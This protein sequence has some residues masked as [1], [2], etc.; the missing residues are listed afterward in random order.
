M[1]WGKG[2]NRNLL[3]E[4]RELRK[5]VKA[6][7][8]E[9]SF[10]RFKLQEFY[11]KIFGRRKKKKK[12]PK[13]NDQDGSNE[14]QPKKPGA[15]K[16][17][18]GWFRTK[19][20]HIDYIKEVT[21][22]KCPKCGS[23]ELRDL[24]KVQEHIQED[25]IIITRTEATCYKKNQYCCEEC[26]HQV[27][28]RG[29]EELPNSY[30][31]PRAK[32]LAVYLK[33]HI[34]MSDRDIKRLFQSLL[35]LTIVPSSIP[36]FRNQLTRYCK[37]LYEKLLE[38][39]KN[40]RL[41]NIDETGWRNNGEVR[42]L[43]KFTNQDVSINQ[44]LNGRGQKDL[45]DV[46]GKKYNGIII[47]DF[48]SAYNK[49]KA[50]AKQRCLVHLA[51]DI[52]KIRERI[53]DDKVAMRFAG[54]LNAIIQK[55]VE[56]A[57]AYQ[58]REISRKKLKRERKKLQDSLD[59]LK[60]ADPSHKVLRRLVL[61][62]ERHKNELLTFLD[63]PGIDYHNNH[64]ERQIRPNV[65]LR[66][67]VFGNRSDKG[68]LNHNCLMSIIQTAHLKKQDPLG[69]LQTFLFIYDKPNAVASVIPP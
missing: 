50:K 22:K 41:L 53:P 29:T 4:N 11:E 69:V 28:G 17:H 37:P 55:A 15:P 62:L 57:N 3:N 68:I 65:L 40:S 36:G 58:S 23:R 25:I 44:I 31:G 56:L 67:I 18:I 19:P 43:W 54:R 42:W 66:K 1:L 20:K 32:A 35:G 46:L 6:L 47:S 38:R 48:L 24:G 52:K 13:N 26:G 21:L 8:E 5:R 14:T 59:D 10:L 2:Q 39:M 64:A 30:I 51:G 63:Y 7:E 45:E 12:D 34:K 60:L 16:G 49:I 61:R 9:N 27:E 33:Y